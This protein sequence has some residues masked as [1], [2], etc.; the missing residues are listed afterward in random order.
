MLKKGINFL[1]GLIA[2]LLTAWNILAALL[3]AGILPF[4][5]IFNLVFVAGY[6]MTK[7]S[8]KPEESSQTE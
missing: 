5:I 1:L 2:A 8:S 7:E 3:G 6:F 4:M